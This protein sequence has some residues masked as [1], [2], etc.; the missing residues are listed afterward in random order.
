MTLRRIT[1]RAIIHLVITR[2]CSQ[3]K[4]YQVLTGRH[5]VKTGNPLLSGNTFENGVL[6]PCLALSQANAYFDTMEKHWKWTQ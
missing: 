5:Q 4:D 2:R 6:P 3:A 1:Y